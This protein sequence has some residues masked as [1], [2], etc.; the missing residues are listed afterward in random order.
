MASSD[1][2]LSTLIKV[3]DT[4]CSIDINWTCS[5]CHRYKR[6]LVTMH[7]TLMHM[8][9][10]ILMRMKQ[11][12]WLCVSLSC[13]LLTKWLTLPRLLYQQSVA[14][15]AVSHI[16][17]DIEMM[18]DLSM[19][20]SDN[21]ESSVVHDTSLTDGDHLSCVELAN[22]SAT[23][24]IVQLSRKNGPFAKPTKVLVSGQDLYCSPQ[25]GLTVFAS[26]LCRSG[27]CGVASV[28]TRVH[29]L[30]G[31]PCKFRCCEKR[32]PYETF[33][34]HLTQNAQHKANLCE[35]AATS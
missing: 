18:C 35:V 5:H 25:G 33:F 9:I 28:C 22:S 2:W 23:S 32:Q 24:I 15:S 16:F 13:Q 4:L 29:T 34:L 20:I 31:A 7:K 12:A 10:P 6:S 27:P 8:R 19:D 3:I 30:C 11:F 1:V 26:A 17:Y 14:V 21:V